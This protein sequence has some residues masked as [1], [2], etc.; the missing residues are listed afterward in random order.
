MGIANRA[1]YGDTFVSI[2]KARHVS[3]IEVPDMLKKVNENGLIHLALYMPDHEI[4]SG[5]SV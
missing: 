3:L 4:F 2:G 5:P 1:G